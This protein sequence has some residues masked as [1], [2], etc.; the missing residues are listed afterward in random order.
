LI[1]AK[2]HFAPI[3]PISVISQ[4]RCRRRRRRLPKQPKAGSLKSSGAYWSPSSKTSKT[5]PPQDWLRWPAK[6]CY[7][8][9]T[10]TSGHVLFSRLAFAYLL[11]GISILREEG[12]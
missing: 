10:L 2:F 5:C 6:L 9:P 3:N 8:D 12:Y 4:R 1:H 7:L 11:V